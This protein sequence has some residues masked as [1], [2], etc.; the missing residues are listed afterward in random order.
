M[1]ASLPLVF[2]GELQKNRKR[3]NFFVPQRKGSALP[4]GTT[5]APSKTYVNT[6]FQKVKKIYKPF[7]ISA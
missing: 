7:M 3:L 5:L 6:F 4:S 2:V 1:S